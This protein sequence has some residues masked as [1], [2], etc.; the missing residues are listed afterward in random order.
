MNREADNTER[1][2]IVGVGNLLLR[3][4]GIGI[5]CARVLQEMELPANV[6][7]I[8]GGTSPDLIS[9]VNK[10]DKL[11]IIDAVK[12]GAEPGAVYRF[13]PA[14]LDQ[15]HQGLLSLH[16]LGLME[17]LYMMRLGGNE[18]RETVIIGIEPEEVTL[19]TELTPRLTQKLP[20]IVKIIMTEIA[21]S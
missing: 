18:P 19:S 10:G 2:V 8:D 4:E 1:I 12:A 15:Q 6:E 3:D 11:V 7:V 16:E 13:T 9:Y 20:Q 21:E 5:H 17:S 14:D